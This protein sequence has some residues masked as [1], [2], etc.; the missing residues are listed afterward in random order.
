MLNQLYPGATLQEKLNHFIETKLFENGD[1]DVN[2]S[3]FVFVRQCPP[4]NPAVMEKYRGLVADGLDT[5]LRQC[6]S[7]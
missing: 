1:H 2:A 7:T 5:T 3:D 6:K 4:F